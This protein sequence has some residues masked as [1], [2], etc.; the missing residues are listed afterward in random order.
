M[1][2]KKVCKK[3]GFNIFAGKIINIINKKKGNVNIYNLLG[4]GK[5][6]ILYK[7]TFT[8]CFIK[9]SISS[10]K[11]KI[12]KAAITEFLNIFIE[13]LNQIIKTDLKLSKK[14][15]YNVHRLMWKHVYQRKTMRRL[16]HKNDF[17]REN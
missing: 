12:S 4:K 7:G 14:K 17:A 10:K 1:T 5:K 9:N 3:H 8:A 6:C 2:I 11:K 16:L 15:K 13:T